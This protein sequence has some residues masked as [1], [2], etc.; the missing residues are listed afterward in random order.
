LVQ[1]DREFVPIPSPKAPIKNLAAVTAKYF[2]A[3]VGEY[4]AY[5]LT[6][7]EKIMANI[8]MKITLGIDVSKDKLDIYNWQ[9]AELTTLENERSAIK[10]WLREFHNPVQIAIE[11]TSHYHLVMVEEAHALAY[12]VYLIN[13]RQIVHY[14]I[15]VNV[16]N[17]TDPLDAW[18]LAR[19]LE[20]E[21]SQIRPF[22]PQDPKAQRLWQ[23]ILRRATTVKSRQQLRQSF[24][25]LGIS[26]KGVLTQYQQLLARIDRQI[27]GL[28][29]EL[30]WW[31][32]YQ[33]CLSIPGIGAGNASA[34]VAAYH[35]GS[36]ASSDAFVSYLGLDVR[37]RE[38]GYYK[39]K[40]K[41]TKQ[42]E[43]ELRRLLFC[44]SYA[45]R[46]CQ[47]FAEYY[48]R[49]LVQ[50]LSKIAARVA[51]SRKLA[52]IAFTLMRNEEMFI[53]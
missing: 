9:T 49:K 36:F 19:Y 47:R 51:L 38:S 1:T 15:A 29:R 23:L 18:L 33:Y 52:R 17:K 42:G 5:L 6:A 16:R 35:R 3:C 20:S 4:P 11:P 32:E 28:I 50:G 21:G 10:A 45:A 26:I 41:L 31:S 13:P 37:I 39:G 25:G 14:R 27:T 12:D 46:E 34:L 44:A 53:K 22:R 8:V 43:P 40:R 30:G 48:Q 24:T 7:A 2:Q